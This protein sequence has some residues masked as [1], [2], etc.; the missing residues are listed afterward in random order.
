M[1]FMS[2]LNMCK[3]LFRGEITGQGMN[4]GGLAKVVS[5]CL[6][7]GHDTFERALSQLFY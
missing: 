1:Y 2:S 5:V 4:L 7:V 3:Y 6:V